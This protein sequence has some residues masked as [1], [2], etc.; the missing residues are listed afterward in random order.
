MLSKIFYN[1][2]K[3]G[4][5]EK[6]HF[7]SSINMLKMQHSKRQNVARIPAQCQQLGN[8]L[9]KKKKWKENPK[10]CIGNAMQCVNSSGNEII[11]M[12]VV[13]IPL[14]TP[15]N[16]NSL[17]YQPVGPAGG[18]HLGLSSYSAE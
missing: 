8:Y 1:T 9:N 13:K 14:E 3:H 11:A 5:S 16:I 15:P 4:C 17:K 10:E 18:S 2:L 7:S 6:T 12:S